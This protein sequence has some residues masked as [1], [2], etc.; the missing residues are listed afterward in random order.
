MSEYFAFIDESGNHDLDTSKEGVSTYYVVAA[1]VCKSANVESLTKTVDVI[2]NKHYGTGE[3][4]SSKTKEDRRLRVIN[5]LLDIDF[6]FTAIAV[7]KNELQKIGG[8]P[9]KKSF[10][11]FLHGILYKSLVATYQD[12]SIRADEHGREEFMIGFRNYITKNHI[13]DL[14]KTCTVEHVKSESNVLVQLA[15]FLAGTIRIFYEENA[16]KDLNE[17]FIKLATKSRLSIEEWP[18]QHF[19]RIDQRPDREEHDEVVF[20]VAMNSAASFVSENSEFSD[21]EIQ[22]QL[23]VL[24]YL[25]FQAQF[26]HTEYISSGELRDH[27][28]ACGYADISEHQFKSMVISKLR[29]CD[30]LISSSNRGYKI[31]QTHADYMDFVELVNGQTIPLLDRLRRAKKALFEASLGEIKT[32]D[33][34]QYEKLKRVIDA[35]GN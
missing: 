8:F 27:L 33:D 24:K 11:K 2:K 29:D 35:L 18:P 9:H 13:P 12:I 15:D 23:I 28:A 34:P 19:R 25:L 21:E 31:P 4:K 32:F 5:D 26:V 10:V 30:V 7:N 6:K 3:I 20:T 22:P 1:I 14:F 17:A 16:S